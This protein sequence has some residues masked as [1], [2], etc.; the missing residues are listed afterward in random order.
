MIEAVCQSNL[1]KASED[2]LFI[3]R[4]TLDE[5]QAQCLDAQLSEKLLEES[6]VARE[7]MQ[8]TQRTRLRK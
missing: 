8:E 4:H 5:R 7:L 1:F 2:A 3:W 6:E